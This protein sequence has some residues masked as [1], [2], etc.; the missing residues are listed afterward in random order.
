MLTLRV[1]CVFSSLDPPGMESV[2]T[3]THVPTFIILC[4]SAAETAM[5]QCGGRGR[6]AVLLALHCKN[7]ATSNISGPA[8]SSSSSL[9]W[10]VINLLCFTGS[11]R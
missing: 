10:R 9:P 5:R 3:L 1:K 7:T 6:E 11:D 2:S 4:R 8:A